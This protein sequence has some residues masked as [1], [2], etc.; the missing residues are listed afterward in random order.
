MNISDIKQYVDDRPQEGVFR[1][2]R[3]V[4]S[5]PELFELEQR[6]IFERTWQFLTLESEIADPNDF[7]TAW[8]GRT[9]VLITRDPQGEVRAFANV[10]RHKGSVLC[11]QERGNAKYHSCIY[12]GWSYD[13]TG[14]NIF[15]KDAKE[16][17]YAGAFE[18]EN[19]DLLPIAKLGRYKGL[20]FG[21]LSAAV[22]PIEEFLGELRFFIDLAMEQ[23]PQGME[24]VPGRAGYTFAGNWKLQMDNG[25]DFYHLT[26]TH[27]SFIA[28]QQRRAAGEGHQE[29]RMYDWSKRLDQD[30]GM[31]QF[32]HGH[33]VGWLNQVEVEKR[34]IYPEI[35]RIRERLGDLRADWMLKPR[36]LVVF[37]NMQI[38][39]ATALLL[40]VF[41]PLA[42]DRTEMQVRCLAPI[43]EPAEQRAWRLRQF[44]DFFNASGFATPDDTMMYEECQTGFS[45]KPLDY[46]QG[47]A[48]GIAALEPGADPLA[49]TIGIEPVASQHGAYRVQNEVLF[50]PMYR[51]WAR[52]I[53]CGL[54]GKEAYP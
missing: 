3:K 45:A 46:L 6:Y 47:Y 29:A 11:R 18:A 42:P 23:S 35:G 33:T 50:H 26:S 19:H 2:H 43:G 10:C 7:V 38:A 14:R 21:S 31:F 54:A 17:C 40:R 15:I 51:E 36:N 4:F 53:E 8:I 49:R 34:P 20:V 1:V 30:A 9:P 37:P 13:A 44:E 12:H 16:A 32:R 22:P 24:F 48:R 39:D 5:D 41:R 25:V 28:V 27:R 52:L